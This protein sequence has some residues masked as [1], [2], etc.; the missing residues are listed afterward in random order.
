MNS[1]AAAAL[2]QEPRSKAEENI[3]R[4]PSRP[5]D[6]S[7]DALSLFWQ[8]LYFPEMRLVSDHWLHCSE[9]CIISG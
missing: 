6:F 3:F 2:A 4:T 1:A 5:E 7:Y 9:S 8:G